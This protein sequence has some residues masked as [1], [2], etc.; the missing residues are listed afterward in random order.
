MIDEYYAYIDEAGDEGF[1]KLKTSNC[2][3]QSR[4]LMLGAIVV[5]KEEDRQLPKWRDQ[6]LL[7]FPSKKGR[8]LHFN[9]LKHEQKVAACK[10]LSDKRFGACVICSDKLT[11]PTLRNE[12]LEKYKEKGHL[13]NYLVRYLLER[14]S[15]ACA[16]KSK[17]AGN[18]ARVFVTFSKRGG[19][20]YNVMRDYL[21]LMR[22]GREVL[23]PV[24]SIDWSVLHPEDIGVEDH[25]NRAGLQIADVVTSATYNAFE[26]N[27]YG[28]TEA[29]YASLFIPRYLKEGNGIR[30]CGVTLVP[31]SAIV[32]EQTKKFLES[33]G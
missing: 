24:R 17:R 25:S 1:G 10:F 4:W 22:D 18:K 3:G 33:L 21:Y 9:K 7:K 31:R 5:S 13:Y 19:T 11:I 15:K 32:H 27:L 30:G 6:V 28:D 8:D 23:R 16:E 29:R 2:G 12:L 20:D 14:V 26:Q